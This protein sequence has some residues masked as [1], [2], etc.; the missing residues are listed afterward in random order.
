MNPA[1][2]ALSAGRLINGQIRSVSMVHHYSG[3]LFFI[4]DDNASGFGFLEQIS[5]RNMQC[6]ILPSQMASTRAHNPNP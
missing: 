3:S 6:R 2:L 5:G 4:D 1:G